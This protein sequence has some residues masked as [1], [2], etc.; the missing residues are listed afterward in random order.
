VDG[1]KDHTLHNHSEEGENVKEKVLSKMK[2]LTLM[3]E[4]VALIGKVDRI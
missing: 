3:M 4:T 1:T 2:A